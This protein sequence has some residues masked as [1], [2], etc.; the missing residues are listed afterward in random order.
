MNTGPNDHYG[1][2]KLSAFIL[3]NATEEDIV[4]HAQMGMPY[5]YTWMDNLAERQGELAQLKERLARQGITLYNAGD[6]AVAKSAHIHLATEHRD[7]DIARFNDML[8]ALAK[9][10]IFTTTFTWEP[11]YVW[12]TAHA[13]PGRGGAK[14]R[15]VDEKQLEQVPIK[16]GRIYEK[17]E[18]WENFRYFI[19]RVIPVSEET[20]VRLAL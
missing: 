12:S 15:M 20:G 18:M 14:V 6:M 7:R 2:I 3:H 13:V 9:T 8:R 5:A 4:L 10:G 16:H 19:E 1:R 11:D 17:D